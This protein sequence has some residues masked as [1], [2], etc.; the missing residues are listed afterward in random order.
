LAV[1]D[2][3]RLLAETGPVVV[4]IDDAQWL[5]PASAGVLQIAFSGPVKT[6]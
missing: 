1:L 2:A 5:D 3:L 4:A 6:P